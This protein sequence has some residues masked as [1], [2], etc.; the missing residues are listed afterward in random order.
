MPI[1]QIIA[2]FASG[3]IEPVT[4]LISERVEDKDLALRINAEITALAMT[5]QANALDAAKD[6]VIAEANG[7]SWLQR[8][9]RPIVMLTFGGL[10]VARWLGLTAP[11]LTE[12]LELKLM[13]ILSLGIG[14]YVIGRSGEKIAE[15][16]AGALRGVRGK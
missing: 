9:W 12:A 1:A 16:A 4:R 6:V 15:A 2:G 13:E 7:E 8:S 5:E 14:G 10:I 11:G 3:L